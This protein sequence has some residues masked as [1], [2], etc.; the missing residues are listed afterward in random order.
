MSFPNPK[1]KK[2]K[3]IKKTKQAFAA[4]ALALV[5]LLIVSVGAMAQTTTPIKGYGFA[6]ARYSHAVLGEDKALG[7]VGFLTQVSGPLYTAAYVDAGAY[8][9]INNDWIL[10]APVQP[11]SKFYVGLLAG[12]D[13]DFRSIGPD[14]EIIA[15]LTGAGGI[16]CAWQFTGKVAGFSDPGIWAIAKYSFAVDNATTYVNGWTV[17]LGLF[18][19]W[20]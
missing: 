14:G 12:P 19:P 16:M 20:Q 10:L 2:T 8:G 15:Y 18:L 13:A 7:S 17:G 6:G 5:A 1:T 9:K 3:K 11:T 4:V